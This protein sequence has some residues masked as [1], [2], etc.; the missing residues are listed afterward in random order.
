M[1]CNVLGGSARPCRL[2]VYQERGNSLRRFNA[3]RK[4]SGLVHQ[5]EGNL[6]HRSHSRFTGLIIDADRLICLL[7]SAIL[8]WSVTHLFNSLGRPN[9]LCELKLLARPS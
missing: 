1:N 4:K 5:R 2:D 8:N 6:V 7:A 9:R 3:H